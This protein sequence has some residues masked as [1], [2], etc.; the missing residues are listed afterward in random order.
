M[1]CGFDDEQFIPIPFG[2]CGRD[3]TQ[4]Q[5]HSIPIQSRYSR[6]SKGIQQ[7][8]R[9]RADWSTCIRPSFTARTLLI[10]PADV[11]PS[12]A[13]RARSSY[14]SSTSMLCSSHQP[15]T[16]ACVRS[17]RQTRDKMLRKKSTRLPQRSLSVASSTA[18]PPA[19]FLFHVDT[20]SF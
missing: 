19:F 20:A 4:A 7:C 11:P 5:K 16:T 10:R 6:R 17:R 13:T 14:P 12:T 8:L 1:D 15:L 3:A 2:F 9:D 18:M